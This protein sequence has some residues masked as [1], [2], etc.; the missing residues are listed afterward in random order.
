MHCCTRRRHPYASM[1]YNWTWASLFCGLS[2]ASG[3]VS[4]LEPGPALVPPPA[5]EPLLETTM[6]CSASSPLLYAGKSAGA[7]GQGV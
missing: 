2:P 4:V 3:A 5:L 1:Y 7:C 6:G